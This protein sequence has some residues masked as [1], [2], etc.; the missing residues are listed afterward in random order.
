MVV[1]EDFKNLHLTNAMVTCEIRLFQNYFSL[2]RRLSE[3]ILYTSLFT[4]KV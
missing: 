1:D 4:H 3:I 2:H